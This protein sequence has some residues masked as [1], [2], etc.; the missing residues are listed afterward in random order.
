MVQGLMW[1]LAVCA[2]AGGVDHI[3]GDRFGLGDKFAQACMLMG[4]TALSM[5]GILCLAPLLA[6]GIEHTLSPLYRRMGLDAG[7]LGGILAIDMGGYPLAVS[8]ARAPEVGRYAGIIVASTFGCTVTFTIPVGMGMLKDD[9]RTDFSRG[10]LYGLT[11]L[12][13]ALLLGG[14]LSGLKPLAW[15]WQSL[16]LLLLS[17][18]VLLGLRRFTDG[19]IRGFSAFAKLLSALATLGLALGAA[20]MMTGVR[21]IANLA[22][23]ED[24][25]AVVASIAVMMLG[26][27]PFAELLKRLLKRPMARV[28]RA[29]G[30]NGAGVAGLLIGMVSVMP[31]IALVKDMDRRSRIVNA[32]A[33]VCSASALAAHLGFAAGVDRAMILPMLAAKLAGGVLG[34]ALA[35]IMT[36][37]AKSPDPI[38]P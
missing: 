21:W 9:A 34:A 12:P 38:R 35:L 20:Q 2:I 4:P 7:T 14:L 5:A 32:A 19:M 16:P 22:P 23:V 26:S 31:A 17:A 37:K 33:M 24:G 3:L 27:L 10:M 29:T 25:M 15:L 1:I 6:E 30:M 8:L 18:L 11:A 13:A 28:G 36:G